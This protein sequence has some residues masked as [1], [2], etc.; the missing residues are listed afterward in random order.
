MTI[1]IFTTIIVDATQAY[2][3]FFL[4]FGAAGLAPSYTLYK[5]IYKHC[6]PPQR[7]LPAR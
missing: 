5:G 4:R 1:G 7:V 3:R 2:F 6:M